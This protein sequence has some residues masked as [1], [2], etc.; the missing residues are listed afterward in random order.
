MGSAQLVLAGKL[1]SWLGIEI[2]LAQYPSDRDSLLPVNKVS[3]NMSNSQKQVP[4]E[5]NKKGSHE[6][7]SMRSRVYRQIEAYICKT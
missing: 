6:K 5:K 7:G 2:C 4:R 1:L 3:T